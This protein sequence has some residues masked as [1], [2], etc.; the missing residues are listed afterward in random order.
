MDILKRLR[1]RAA[2]RLQHI[3]LP[4]GEDDRTIVAASKIAEERL[5]RITLLGDEEKIR[6][7]AQSLG[8]SLTNVPIH[9]HRRSPDLEGY[10]REFYELRRAKGVTMEEAAKQILDLMSGHIV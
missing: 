4:E 6:N 7:R 1:V 10:A 5:A 3:V 8:V 2:T 9:D